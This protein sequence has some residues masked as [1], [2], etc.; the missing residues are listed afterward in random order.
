MNASFYDGATG[1]YSFRVGD[2]VY[3]ELVASLAVF[4]STATG[5]RAELIASKIAE[6]ALIPCTLSMK[7]FSYDACLKVSEEYRDFVL[8]DIRRDYSYMLD[9]GATTAW[10]TLKGEADFDG[11]GSLCHGWNAMPIVYYHRLGLI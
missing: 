1:Q 8:T 11:A 10:E 7:C 3:T 4:T 2:G 6:G 9:H 5:E